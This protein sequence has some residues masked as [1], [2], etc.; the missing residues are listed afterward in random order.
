MRK[1]TLLAVLLLYCGGL[2]AKQVKDTGCGSYS[3]T[4][5]GVFDHS[6]TFANQGGFDLAGHMPFSPYVEA[7]AGFEFLG[8]KTVAGTL[9][10][11]PKLPLK[12]GE[13]FLEAAVHMR[14]FNTSSIGTFAIAGSFGYRMDYV[15]VQAGIE[16]TSIL[17]LARKSGEPQ[18][19]V[20]EL[21]FIFKLA[22]NVRPATSPWNILLGASNFT[23]Y[24]YERLY[25]PIFFLGGHY[26]FTGNLTALAQVDLKPSGI[27]NLSAHF[28]ELAIRAGITYRF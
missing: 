11:R 13:L 4:V 14:A 26:D 3:I 18:S 2:F 28:N 12:T 16:R 15:S 6:R 9:V 10:A 17:D 27:F 22:F 24:Q 21:N 1:L 7:D 19:S 23:L 8:P 25:Y 20:N 5:L